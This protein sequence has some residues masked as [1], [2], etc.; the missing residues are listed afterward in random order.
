MVRYLTEQGLQAEAF[1]TEYGG[2]AVEADAAAE[3][4]VTPT[5]QGA[6]EA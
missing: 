5:A 3:P 4:A 1:D 2:D 6:G